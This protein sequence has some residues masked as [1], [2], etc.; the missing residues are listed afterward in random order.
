M[1]S[2]SWLARS[3][4]ADRA[5]AEQG[6]PG[7]SPHH[8]CD[9][10]PIE[11]GLPVSLVVP[12]HPSSREYIVHIEVKV[13][14]V[15]MR[16][17]RRVLLY[18]KSQLEACRLFFSAE[19]AQKMSKMTGSQ[20]CRVGLRAPEMRRH[21]PCPTSAHSNSITLLTFLA[22]LTCFSLCFVSVCFFWT[23]GLICCGVYA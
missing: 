14:H 2:N 6:R 12:R 5:N 3:R 15:E 17:Q 22:L 8:P 4:E 11:L 1:P 9:R 18:S 16:A 21:S 10:C 13:R 20:I 7:N 23:S 19:V